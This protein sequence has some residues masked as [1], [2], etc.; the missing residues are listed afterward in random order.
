MD[1]CAHTL[2]LRMCNEVDFTPILETAV[3]ECGVK[4]LERAEELLDAFL[5]WF[6]LIPETSSARPLQM[7]RSVDR[8]WH[9]MVLHTAFYREFC[10]QFIGAF[11]DHNPLDVVRTSM[12]KQAYAKHT[13]AL[14]TRSYG[15]CVNAN[16]LELQEDV[17]CCIGCG[18]NFEEFHREKA[19]LV[20]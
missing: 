12:E 5:Q 15:D 3:R 18:K 19:L 2:Y 8:I 20:R 17:T 6:S 4:T 10:D 9:A 7:L 1:S 16:L 14:L 13:L 11:V